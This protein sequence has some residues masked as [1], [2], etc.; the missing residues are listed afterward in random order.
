MAASATA[1]HTRRCPQLTLYLH[2]PAM[3]T[4]EDDKS[5]FLSTLDQLFAKYFEEKENYGREKTVQDKFWGTYLRAMKDEDEARPKDWD[6]NTGSILTFTGLFAATV[7][8]FVIEGYKSLSRDA[9]DQTVVL[10]TQLLAAT[11]NASS[12]QATTI[13]SSD[14]FH[15]PL[16]AVLANALWFISLVVALACAL[17]A[18]LVQQ[19]SRDYV[20]DTKLRD[21]LDEP[22]VSRALNHVYIRMGVDRYGMDGVVNLIVSLVH[23]AVILFAA[24]LLL[25]LFPID[26]VVSWCTMSALSIFGSAYLVAGVL[27]IIDSSCPYRTPLTYPLILGYS[28]CAYV[29]DM[30]L[31]QLLHMYGFYQAL[32]WGREV[33]SHLGVAA[34]LRWV[35]RLCLVIPMRL[36]RAWRPI[37]PLFMPISWRIWEQP[38]KRR[39]PLE[40]SAFMTDLRFDFLWRHTSRQMISANDDFLHILLQSAY[41]ILGETSDGD[42]CID[43]LLED[44]QLGTKLSEVHTPDAEPT[45]RISI[46]QIACLLLRQCYR[47]FG[48]NVPPPGY[49]LMDLFSV[50][51]SMYGVHDDASFV[52]RARMCLFHLRW[53]LLL[54]HRE[55]NTTADL[56]G[57]NV[58][59]FNEVYFS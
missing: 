8:A 44:G 47:R 51:G 19:W 17:L 28:G 38:G 31:W 54:L 33:Y 13:S 24:G 30:Y 15:A 1:F 23:L 12:A 39:R 11:T 57:F 55:R 45:T 46:L 6:G 34:G 32:E 43:H 48:I 9:G 2:R 10:L 14:D 50:I 16:S 53:S 7:A 26:A 22:I 27:P 56:I 41:E 29:S 36:M 59:E 40:L 21:T 5:E 3:P 20:R 58:A 35:R 25:F 49:Y 42:A 52:L 18:T 4:S 37:Q